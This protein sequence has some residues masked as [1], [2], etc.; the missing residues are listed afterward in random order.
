MLQ[1]DYFMK[2]TQKLAAV[3]TKILLHKETK[4]YE[5]AEKEI[6]TA[7]KTI[8]GLDL[9]L[10]S[11]LSAEDVITLMKSS[12]VYAGR[13]LVSAE[14]LKEYAD[15]LSEKDKSEESINIYKKSLYLYVEAILTK[16]LP[17]PEEYYPRINFFIINLSP[18]G[19]TSEFKLKLIEYFEIS[20]QFSKAEDMIFDIADENVEGFDKKALSFYNRLQSKSDDELIKGNL[21][22]EEI[23][24][25]LEEIQSKINH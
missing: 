18:L 12:D 19:F 14:L 21:S 6:E 8:V 22:R 11:V 3:L 9:K 13:C 16:E 4:N 15:I 24:E 1:R 25:S 2:M 10:I 17:A 20:G 23:R 7:A 5:D